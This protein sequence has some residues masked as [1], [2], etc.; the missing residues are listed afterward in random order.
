V[1][2]VAPSVGAPGR[3]VARGRARD[4][5]RAVAVALALGGCPQPPPA[6]PVPTPSPPPPSPCREHD[7]PA[8]LATFAGARCPWLLRVD[9]GRLVLGSLDPDPLPEVSGALPECGPVPCTFDGAETSLGPMVVASVPSA[10]SEMP[11]RVHLGVVAPTKT[12]VFVDLWAGAGETVMSDSTPLGP[13]LALAPFDCRG[14]L[15]LFAVPRLDIDREL[16]PPAE[17]RAREGL[18]ALDGPE[19]VVAPIDRAGCKRLDVPLP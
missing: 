14:E 10:H 4:V 6:E 9:S 19:P 5:R 16:E 2:G 13:A 17:L 7:D 18:Y 8:A 15:G 3:A 1:R 11:A 12:L